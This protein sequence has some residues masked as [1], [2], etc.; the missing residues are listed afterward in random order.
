MEMVSNMLFVHAL[1]SVITFSDQQPSTMKDMIIE[2]SECAAIM[3]YNAP[4]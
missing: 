3:Q 1:I 4:S 2:R